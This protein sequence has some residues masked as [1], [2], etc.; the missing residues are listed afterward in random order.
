MSSKCLFLYNQ[1]GI[2]IKKVKRKANNPINCS[3]NFDPFF[4]KFHM[5]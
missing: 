1:T 2:N 5:N 4:Q 3:C